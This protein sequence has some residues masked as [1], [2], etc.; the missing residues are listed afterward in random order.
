M[1]DEEQGDAME[2]IGTGSGQVVEA[3]PQPTGEVEAL[4][5]LLI[6]DDPGEGTELLIL[7]PES[8]Y[9]AG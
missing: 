7:E 2:V 3:A 4:E 9:A 1:D 6:D 5:E 8:G